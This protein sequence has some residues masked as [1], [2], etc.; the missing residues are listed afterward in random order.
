MWT[1][2]NPPGWGVVTGC[3]AEPCSPVLV[4]EVSGLRPVCALRSEGAAVKL[5]DFGLAAMFVE[6][7]P[8]SE[9]LGSAYYVAPEV[10]RTAPA[11]FLHFRLRCVAIGVGCDFDPAAS[12]LCVP[13][14]PAYAVMWHL[15]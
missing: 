12:P 10:G 8:L 14:A 11:D 4:P 3:Q 1:N 5:T 13:H 9:V 15:Q 7:Q 6:G 2:P